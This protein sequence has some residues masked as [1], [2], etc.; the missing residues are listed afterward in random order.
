[1]PLYFAYGVNMHQTE[2]AERCPGAKLLGPARLARH[3]FHVMAQGYASVR[4]DPAAV[5]YG[6]LWEINLAH[7]RTL[8]AFEELARGLYVKA[9]QP[10][11]PLDAAVNG[12]AKRA[13]IYLG[14]SAVNGRAQPGYMERVLDAAQ[15]AGFPKSYLRELARWL[16]APAARAGAVPPARPVASPTAPDVRPRFATPLDPGRA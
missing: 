4:R 3:R 2:M 5:T 11:I 7:V 8:D 9:Q 14:A 16:P 15:E 10:V 6:L 13:M 1:M 12:A